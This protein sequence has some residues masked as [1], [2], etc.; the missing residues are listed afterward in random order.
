MTETGKSGTRSL[1]K[2]GKHLAAISNTLGCAQFTNALSELLRDFV[3]VDEISI[4]AYPPGQL[5]VIEYREPLH[6]TTEQNLDTFVLGAFVLD[7]YYVAATQHHKEGF[8]TVK[9][10]APRGFSESEYYRSY[11][12]YSGLADE[13]GYLLFSRQGG[14]INISLGRTNNGR[15]FTRSETNVLK[16]L[17]GTI[18]HLCQLHGFGLESDNSGSTERMQIDTAIDNFGSSI[19]TNREHEIVSMILHGHAGK[20]IAAI[21]GIS[22][23][24][25][26]L[27]RRNAYHKLNV[28]SQVELFYSFIHSL[29]G[30]RTQPL[31]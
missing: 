1:E 8:F 21:L 30:L 5:P 31:S 15:R 26:K 12:R 19:L 16:D 23:E 18:T 24:T 27:H 9:E 4:I 25:V 29:P 20:Q 14:F 11:Y 28:K 6:P 13:C 17:T 10:L 7:P 22:L 2:L 3:P